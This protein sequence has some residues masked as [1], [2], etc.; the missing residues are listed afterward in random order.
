MMINI[1]LDYLRL[2]SYAIVIL[3]ALKGIA[4]KT[5]SNALFFGDI[6]VALGLLLTGFYINILGKS[7]ALI[8]DVILTPVAVVWAVIHFIVMLKEK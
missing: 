2:T 3:L 4:K 5:L 8:E 7:G 6:M 1:L